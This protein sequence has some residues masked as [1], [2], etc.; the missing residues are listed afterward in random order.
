VDYR[1]YGAEAGS[2][3]SSRRKVMIE[4]QRRAA[5]ACRHVSQQLFRNGAL[6]MLNQRRAVQADGRRFGSRRAICGT[7]HD[8]VPSAG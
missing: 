5:N 6:G 7:G 1:T 3:R 2:E 4:R 8:E